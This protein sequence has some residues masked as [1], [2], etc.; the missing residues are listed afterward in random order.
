M[1]ILSWWPGWCV[2]YVVYVPFLYK[3]GVTLY[4][5]A[6]QEADNWCFHMLW[7]IVARYCMQQLWVTVSR[8]HFVTNKY[9]INEYAIT[10]DQV[11]RE[12]HS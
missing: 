4:G 3:L 5:G 12:F 2:Q 8:L 1:M 9:E 11:D 10:F 7:L 6:A